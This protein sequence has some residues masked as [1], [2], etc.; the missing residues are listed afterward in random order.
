MFSSVT[1]VEVH[2]IIYHMCACGYNTSFS[3]NA[4]R[5]KNSKCT[6]EMTTKIREF[7]FKED[8][9]RDTK[10]MVI[11]G[12]HAHVD[13]SVDNSVQNI[14]INLTVPA[15]TIVGSIYDALA[16]QEC[17]DAIRYADSHQIPAILFKYTR[18]TKAENRIIKYDVAKNAV[19]FLDPVTGTE[20][21]KDLKKYRN[22]YLTEQADVYDEAH[23]IQYMPP[24]IQ[25]S[26]KELSKPSLANGKKKERPI[27]AG[28]VIK[29]C[30]A[31]D[32]RM[33]KLPVDT[34]QFFTKVANDVDNE[35][36][37]AA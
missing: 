24:E 16:N 6:Q 34:K 33:Y 12:D 9:D 37:S 35:I 11:N 1:M 27:P 32:H 31:G 5:H 4:T 23:H 36:K 29:M 7:V 15:N 21:S 26:M 10:S 20:V 25:R 17:L 3:S 13:N 14:N 18:G 19:K 2:K 30:A 22:E 28:E 8:Y